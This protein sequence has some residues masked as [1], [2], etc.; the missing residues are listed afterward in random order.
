[1]K[2]LDRFLDDELVGVHFAVNI[3]LATTI[4][5]L[6]LKLAADVNPIWAISAMVAVSDP[7]VTQAVATFR[8]RIV[9]SLIGCAIGLVVLGV[10]GAHAWKLPFAM[11]G[12]VLIS[13]YV[14]R[15]QAMWRQAPITAALIIA[16]GITHHSKLTGLEVGLR[17]VGEVLLGCV[18]G[19]AVAWLMSRIWPIP[20]KKKPTVAASA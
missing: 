9:N 5:W 20:E 1:M 3:F 17:R 6:L 16:A 10:G 12:A 7:Q 14:I 18:V 2:G 15:V 4:V 8:G 11:A 13:S 19:L